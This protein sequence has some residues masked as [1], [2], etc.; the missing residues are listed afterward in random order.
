MGT[1]HVAYT[2]LA[3]LKIKDSLGTKVETLTSECTHSH[4]QAVR[5]CDETEGDVG[6]YYS[7]PALK[8]CDLCGVFCRTLGPP[9]NSVGTVLYDVRRNLTRTSCREF[10]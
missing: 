5:K 8:T 7:Q 9:G 3:V 1:P 2:P 4:S 6:L 10:E